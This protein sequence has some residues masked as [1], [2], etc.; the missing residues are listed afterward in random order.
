MEP[1]AV[2]MLTPIDFRGGEAA[3]TGGWRRAAMETMRQKA[4]P[5]L[6]VKVI[7]VAL[8]FTG[9]LG[10][11]SAFVLDTL[12]SLAVVAYGWRLARRPAASPVSSR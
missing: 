5:W 6:L 9:Q 11:W 8:V 1:M 4:L 10:V 12:V 7:L 3:A 2:T